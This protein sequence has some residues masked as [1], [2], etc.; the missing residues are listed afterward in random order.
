MCLSY[1]SSLVHLPIKLLTSVYSAYLDVTLIKY[2]FISVAVKVLQTFTALQKLLDGAKTVFTEL[3]SIHPLPCPMLF[4]L[5]SALL[6]MG[7][8]SEMITSSKIFTKYL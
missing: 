1:Q 4:Y 7:K 3:S 2:R 8:P 6:A 5:C